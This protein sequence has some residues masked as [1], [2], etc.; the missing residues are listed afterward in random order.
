MIIISYVL[1][2][3]GNL[4]KKISASLHSKYH[5]YECNWDDVWKKSINYLKNLRN[6]SSISNVSLYRKAATDHMAATSR[7]SGEHRNSHVLQE[8]NRIDDI[9]TLPLPNADGTFRSK[10]SVSFNL[11]CRYLNFCFYIRCYNHPH[12]HLQKTALFVEHNNQRVP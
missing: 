11:N 5:Q 9:P 8:L 1:G 4:P 12:V 7:K 2:L 10:K 3:P 6:V